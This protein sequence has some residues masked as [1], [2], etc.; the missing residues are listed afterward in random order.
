LGSRPGG[1]D[2][3][4]KKCCGAFSSEREGPTTWIR[5]TEGG[6]GRINNQGNLTGGNDLKDKKISLLPRAG[7][8]VE[9]YACDMRARAHLSGHSFGYSQVLYEKKKIRGGDNTNALMGGMKQ[10]GALFPM[11]G[12][13]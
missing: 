6:R 4:E 7:A 8:R 13:A 3:R 9:K 10:T 2:T 5:G 11:E 12:A 1:H